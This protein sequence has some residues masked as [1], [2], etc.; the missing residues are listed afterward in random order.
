MSQ[1]P[2]E[3]GTPPNQ[4][5]TS[6]WQQIVDEDIEA[7]GMF[8]AEGMP[9]PQVD[10]WAS[11]AAEDVRLQGD[12]V[13]PA[14]ARCAQ[15]GAPA[16]AALPTFDIATNPTC[17][18]AAGSLQSVSLPSAYAPIATPCRAEPMGASCR[19]H[20]QDLD[21]PD[22]DDEMMLSMPLPNMSLQPRVEATSEDDLPL[23][24]LMARNV[25]TEQDRAE[26]DAG[27]CKVKKMRSVR[28]PALQKQAK[29]GQQNKKASGQKGDS[30]AAETVLA[31]LPLSFAETPGTVTAPV[32][33]CRFPD[34]AAY[35]SCFVQMVLCDMQARLSDLAHAWR[36]KEAGLPP[37]ISVVVHGVLVG[38]SLPSA[39]GQ[40][41]VQ[42][43]DI[44]HSE[45][46]PAAA[47]G[48]RLQRQAHDSIQYASLIFGNRTAVSRGS[49]R[50]CARGDLWVLFP[51]GGEPLLFRG[52]WR[53]VS[54]RGRLHCVAA[55][56]AAS[57]WLR[58]SHERKLTGM[59]G[60][61]T[62]AFS[63]ELDH[64][65][66]LRAFAECRHQGGASTT[67]D[68]G[69]L[70]TLLGAGPNTQTSHQETAIPL[71]P[72]V[73]SELQTLHLAGLNQ[74]QRNVALNV[75]A[76]AS[77]RCSPHAVLAQGVFGSGKS[78]TLAASILLLDRLLSSQKDPRR[79]LLLSQ[80]N[81]AVDNVLH[82]LLGQGWDDFA[83][84]GSFRNVEPELLHRTVSLMATRQAASKELSEALARLP[85]EV[86]KSLQDAVE[87]GVLP[88]RA[89]IWRRRRLV[90]ATTAALHAAEHL[91]PEAFRCAFVFVDEA[92]Q[93]TEPAVFACLR[94]ASARR[95][96]LV[97]DPRQLPPRTRHACLGRSMLERLWDDGPASARVE[98]A[99]Q[100][101]C[102]PDLA[103][104]PNTLF[105]AGRLR[106][107][108]S[109]EDRNS[110]LGPGV[111]P[112]IVILSEGAE[113]RFGHSYRHTSEAQLCSHWVR[114]AMTGN[115]LKAAALG[116]VCLYRPQADACA[117][118]L[119]AASP[120]H[121][122]EAA[123]VDAFQGGEREIIILSCGRSTPAT[124]GD[125]F[126]NCPRRL[127]VAL[128][129]ARRH[130]VV[131]GSET[132]LRHHVH[133]SRLF[134][135][136]CNYGSVFPARAVHA[137]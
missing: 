39:A 13:T 127:N 131:L 33:P 93:L 91:G 54:P 3:T 66:A 95:L 42:C 119:A 75:A 61:A 45:L 87:R 107:G 23:E 90:A 111:P 35:S 106:N 80:T 10:L 12:V 133:L 6:L 37:E 15:S 94:K 99:V 125:F 67:N 34:Q 110:I 118:E 65:D 49:L 104:L 9:R 103:N 137:M 98:L 5:C 25:A 82:I 27:Q 109:A 59:S 48:S 14:S 30:L 28:K 11:C 20:A 17:G 60:F 43:D 21:L 46:A 124:A 31:P 38:V 86:A 78:R 135:V 24:L 22:S 56:V 51:P 41:G 132:F 62:G 114:R 4:A 70:C 92:T 55:N 58:H 57:M 129:R 122:V 64:L 26:A 101:R 68:D 77:D 74:E 83:R 116:V 52:L 130:L 121:G 36:R 105:Y 128:S 115:S 134:E 32:P 63:H 85:P 117:A 136:A 69:L 120:C 112:L 126:A 72:A 71:Q 44:P 123:T 2:L 50:A 81:V 89:P 113:S 108:V 100:Y 102:H 47:I 16:F 88:P 40:G 1:E 8:E 19:V 97:G 76:W 79:I 53:G 73:P 7:H 84:L 96:L 29:A 18:N